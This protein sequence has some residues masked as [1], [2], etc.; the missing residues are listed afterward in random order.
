[1][2]TVAQFLNLNL[3]LNHNLP[4]IGPRCCL[5]AN[6]P[7][8]NPPIGLGLRRAVSGANHVTSVTLLLCVS[9]HC[10]VFSE[11]KIFSAPIFLPSLLLF[12]FGR[13][14]LAL[15]LCS[16]CVKDFDRMIMAENGIPRAVFESAILAVQCM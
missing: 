14:F 13:G 2:I 6:S 16:L 15:L 12:P 7:A 4:H 5:R 10:S 11:L 8:H 9:L 3:T 1:M